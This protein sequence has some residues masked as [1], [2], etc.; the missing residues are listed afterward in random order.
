MPI[1]EP[2]VR[3]ELPS[4]KTGFVKYA[5]T[6]SLLHMNK[7]PNSIAY[8][9]GI[10]YGLDAEH[11]QKVETKKV[12]ITDD[13]YQSWYNCSLQDLLDSGLTSLGPAIEASI[14]QAI[15]KYEGVTS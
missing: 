14:R 11:L 3:I 2:M 5:I 15:L 10:Y 8:V 4:D 7:L 12:Y 13:K 9:Y 6:E 1:T